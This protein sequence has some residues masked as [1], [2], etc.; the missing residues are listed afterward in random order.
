[1]RWY[2]PHTQMLSISLMSPSV[3]CGCSFE[4]RDRAHDHAGL[5]V[6][7][8]RHLLGDPGF[9]QRMTA[10]GRKALDRD[11]GAADPLGHVHLAGAFGL[12]VEQHGAGAAFLDAA[13]VL[14]SGQAE[15][16]AQ[17]PQQRRTRRDIDLMVD[18]D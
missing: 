3:G 5:A 12:A 11:D 18:A 16:V 1:M 9:L 2:V 14:G 6:A 15:G 4:Q 7:A 13:A 10:I 17:H 8:L